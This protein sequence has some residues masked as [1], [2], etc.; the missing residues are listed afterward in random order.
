MDQLAKVFTH[1]RFGSVQVVVIDS[2]EMFAATQVAAALG[3]KDAHS[4]IRQHCREDGSVIRPVIDSLGRTQQMKFISEG[5]VYRLI[6]RSKLPEAE[7]FERWLFDEVAPSL[8]KHEAYLTPAKLQEV[9][10]DPDVMIALLQDLKSERE[11]RE[12]LQAEVAVIQ[13]KA[14]KY[15]EFLDC[16]GLTAFTTIGKHFLGGVE[17]P[18]LTKFL[19][20]HGVLFSREVDK[21]FPPRKGYEQYFRIIPYYRGGYLLNKSV[22]ATPAGIDFIV[23]LYRKHD[24]KVPKRR[25]VKRTATPQITLNVRMSA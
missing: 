12:R 16:E 5:N 6:A 3:Y 25:E 21:C 19:Q 22:K 15:T 14:D 20:G 23:E 9:L 7:Q 10:R 4:A 1:E 11:E 2:K 18:D 17:A 24:G 8:R 13:P